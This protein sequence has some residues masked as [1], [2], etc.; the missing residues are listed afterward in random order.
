MTA[1]RAVQAKPQGYIQSDP[2]RKDAISG[3]GVPQGYIRC[4]ICTLLLRPDVVTVAI[5]GTAA[6]PR[7]PAE[8]LR[9]S[10]SRIPVFRTL[11]R[12]LLP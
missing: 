12:R 6:N 8:G 11:H 9:R 10:Y 1:W 3:S 7:G 5:A 4:Q 2:G